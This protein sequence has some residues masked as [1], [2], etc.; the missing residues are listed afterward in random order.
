LEDGTS[1]SCLA[2][3]PAAK[4]V[5]VAAEAMAL[6]HRDSAEDAT[7]RRRR[8]TSNAQ[9]ISKEGPQHVYMALKLSRRS[10]PTF[11][12]EI[13]IPRQTSMRKKKKIK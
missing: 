5:N 2:R 10:S 1:F 13:L 7:P 12:D 9:N 11:Y 6:S 8:P 4:S 3:S